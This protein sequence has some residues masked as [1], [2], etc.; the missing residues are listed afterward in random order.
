MLKIIRKIISPI[1]HWKGHF[2]LLKLRIGVII[3]GFRSKDKDKI[4]ISLRMFRSFKIPFFPYDFPKKYSEKSVDVFRDEEGYPYVWFEGKKLFFK[5]DWTDEWVKKYY[6]SILR[7]IDQESPHSYFSKVEFYPKEDDVIADL[8]AAEGVFSLKVI[9]SCKKVYLFEADK[10]WTEP[11]ERTFR[12][13]KEKIEIV[14][15]YIGKRTSTDY[16]SIDDYFRDKE[17]TYIK[18]DIEGAEEDMIMGGV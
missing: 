15:K 1:I 13:Y 8:G 4:R 9:S 16:V 18:A 6:V 11:L 17:I 14:N 5:K 7:D 12:D 3:E 10:S 2:Y